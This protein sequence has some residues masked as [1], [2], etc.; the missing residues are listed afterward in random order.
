MARSSSAG[1]EFQRR[2]QAETIRDPAWALIGQA[3]SGLVDGSKPT[4][5]SGREWQGRVE[6]VLPRPALREMWGE[7]LGQL[8]LSPVRA[9]VR[10]LV[11]ARRDTTR[12][13]CAV[14]AQMATGQAPFVIVS[15]VPSQ[16][17]LQRY[18]LLW[19]RVL[20]VAVQVGHGCL[21][22][23]GSLVVRRSFEG[24]TLRSGV[25]HYWL[26]SRLA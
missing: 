6:L 26:W 21:R 5:A 16:P 2:P 23:L 12:L 15:P 20:E 24:R 10:L 9:E 3:L 14:R 11:D 1:S 17:Y 4:A 22:R 19:S 18:L 8:V 25:C 7:T 13:P